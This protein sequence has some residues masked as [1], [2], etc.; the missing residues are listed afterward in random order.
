[1]KRSKYLIVLLIIIIFAISCTTVKQEV[2]PRVAVTEKA[3]SI[4]NGGHIIPAI[5]TIP[6]GEGKCPAIIMLHGTGSNKDEAGDA[7]KMLAPK[8]AKEGIATIRFDFP[9]C[10][11]NTVKYSNY[12]NSYAI[13]ETEAVRTYLLENK[14]IDAKRI[15]VLGWSQGGS[16]ALLVAG[17]N[18]KAYK[19][20]ATWAGALSPSLESMVT[21]EMRKQIENTGLADFDMGFRPVVKLSKQW[22][23][24]LTTYNV[25][26]YA[27]KIQAPIG[28]IHGTVDDTVPYSDSEA[29]QAIAKNKLSKLIPIEGADHLYGVFSGDLTTYKILAEATI[30]WFKETL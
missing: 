25:L 1:M 12:S 27:K 7:Y 18:P 26:T 16:D 6:E 19:S 2:Q 17:A 30:N 20:V 3:I 28:S 21:P 13:A 8:L 24:E 23:E 22:L 29:V 5:L 4:K 10:G 11:D 9:E 14:D 15:G